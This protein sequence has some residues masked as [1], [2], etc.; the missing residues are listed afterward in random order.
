M[1][2][3]ESSR[4]TWWAVL[5]FGN[6]N[7]KGKSNGNSRSPSGMTSKNSNYKYNN[8]YK[9]NSNYNGNSRIWFRASLGERRLC[10]GRPG[11]VW[12]LCLRRRL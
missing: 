1:R 2:L 6:S 7:G 3:W 10:R 11:G 12:G 9:Y 4:L 5:R 8:H